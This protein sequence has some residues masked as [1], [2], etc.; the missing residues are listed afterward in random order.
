MSPTVAQVMA[1]LCAVKRAA[2]SYLK[3]ADAEGFSPLICSYARVGI[4]F[5]VLRHE[6]GTMPPDAP[7]KGIFDTVSMGMSADFHV[8]IQEGATVVR[9]GRALFE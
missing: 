5:D 7:D 2:D 3:K 1:A 9:I 4:G 6:L 8:A